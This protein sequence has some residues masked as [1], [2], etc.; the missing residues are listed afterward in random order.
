MRLSAIYGHKFTSLFPNQ[1]ALMV[2]KSEWGQALSRLSDFQIGQALDRCRVISDWNP[3]IPEFLRLATNL[4]TLEQTIQRVIRREVIDPVT[5]EV[6][7]MVGAYELKTLSTKE[8]EKRI[9]QNY[10]D[11]YERVMYE[12]QGKEN[13]WQPP[14]VIEH[15]QETKERKQTDEVAEQH[16]KTMREGL[17]KAETKK[18]E[19]K[20]PDYNEEELLK[21][22]ENRYPSEDKEESA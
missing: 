1:E 16:L 3:N 5:R 2:A 17:S 21:D 19:Y 13:N 4:P 11:A 6:S 10:I 9:K 14:E 20:K 7:R 22:V 15:V 8:L 12:Q 18:K